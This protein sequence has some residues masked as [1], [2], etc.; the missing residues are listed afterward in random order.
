MN[1]IKIASVK[2]ESPLFGGCV[3]FAINIEKTGEVNKSLEVIEFL[4]SLSPKDWQI[5]LET[6]NMHKFLEP[7]SIQEKMGGFLFREYENQKNKFHTLYENHFAP[8]PMEILFDFCKSCDVMAQKSIDSLLPSG[9][10][11]FSIVFSVK[12][13]IIEAQISN[14]EYIKSGNKISIGYEEI[15]KGISPAFLCLDTLRFVKVQQKNVLYI[16]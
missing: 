7:I 11:L 8:F 4:N 3:L 13:K 14:C 9:S 16:S 10:V 15:Q 1:T 12:G 6:S 5:G 2:K